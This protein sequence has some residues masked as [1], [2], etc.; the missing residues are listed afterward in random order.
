M[1]KVTDLSLKI[2]YKPINSISFFTKE[3][4]KKCFMWFVS[5]PITGCREC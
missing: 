4:F 3:F 5:E 1:D 2:L